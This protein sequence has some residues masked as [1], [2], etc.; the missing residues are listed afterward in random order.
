MKWLLSGLIL[1]ALATVAAADEPQAGESYVRARAALR[2]QGLVPAPDPRPVAPAKARAAL[3]RKGIFMSEPVPS[4]APQFSEINCWRSTDPDASEV[5]CQ[6]LYLE[7]DR[8]GWKKYLIVPIDPQ[9]LTIGSIRRPATVDGLP[10]IPPPLGK[11]LPQIKGSYFAARAMLKRLG[12]R[13]AQNHNHFLTG[14]TC[15][16]RNCKHI[17]ILAEARC[18]GT[19]MAFCTA[20]WISRHHRV[21]KVTTI[22][23]YPEVYFAE[24][25]DRKTLDDDFRSE[26]D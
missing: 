4:P 5:N 22:W 16:D 17:R 7:T 11:D 3:K 24:W 26:T 23:E 15:A 8:Q 9:N 14:R 1:L 25:S 12:F 21:L 13:P 18:S 10:S 2:E 19:G 6:A 20:Y